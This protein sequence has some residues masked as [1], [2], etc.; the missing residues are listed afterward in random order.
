MKHIKNGQKVLDLAAG[1]GD[2]TKLISESVG[3]KGSVISCDINYEML[4]QGRNNLID[5]GILNN[6][7]YVQSD[8]Q[9][10]SFLSLKFIYKNLICQ[11]YN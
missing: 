7:Y 4:A 2:I 3:E 6:V 1:T 10:L 8:A 9:A 11:V 5:K